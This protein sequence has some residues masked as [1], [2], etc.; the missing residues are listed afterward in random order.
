VILNILV[1]D[2]PLQ[3]A[4]N[5]AR[6]HHQW[7]PD[8]LDYEVGALSPETRAALEDLGHQLDLMGE[9]AKVNAVLGLDE[10]IV[11]AA[12]DP[13]GPATAGVVDPSP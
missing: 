6:I 10:G 8:R 9:T 4:V 12:G 3:A 1:D 5:R 7:L 13:R 2:D 11:A